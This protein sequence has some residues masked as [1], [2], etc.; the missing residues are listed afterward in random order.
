YGALPINGSVQACSPAFAN[1][2]RIFRELGYPREKV[3]GFGKCEHFWT[4][5]FP[6]P[7]TERLTHDIR[8][9][10]RELKTVKP[11]EG[12]FAPIIIH[13]LFH[14][15]RPS[16]DFGEEM[17]YSLATLFFGSGN[18]MSY[19]APTTLEHVFG[20]PSVRLFEYDDRNPLTNIPE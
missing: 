19:V 8:K 1:T 7:L 11:L 14:L 2:L 18:E 10:C 9:F 13:A 12:V 5:V 16:K 17:V 15:F 6:S 3:I 4:N 20:D